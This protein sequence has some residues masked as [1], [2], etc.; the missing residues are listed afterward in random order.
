MSLVNASS[1]RVGAVKVMNLFEHACR[2]GC[3]N[4]AVHRLK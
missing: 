2:L 4:S 3:D 1:Q